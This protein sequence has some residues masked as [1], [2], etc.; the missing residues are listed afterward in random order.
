M[1]LL[2]RKSSQE[3]RGETNRPKNHNFGFKMPK[4]A[5]K[6][7]DFSKVILQKKVP[8]GRK[9]FQNLHKFQRL[10]TVAITSIGGE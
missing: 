2:P 10:A 7:Q 1:H 3:K 8:R 5:Q 6:F 9:N 4:I